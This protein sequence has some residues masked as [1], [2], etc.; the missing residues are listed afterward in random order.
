M[1]FLLLEIV[2]ILT[3]WS[4]INSFQ[5]LTIKCVARDCS[6]TVR[7]NAE[8]EYWMVEVAGKTETDNGCGYFPLTTPPVGLL[9]KN[10]IK[11]CKFHYIFPTNLEL[12]IAANLQ[13]IGGKALTRVCMSRFRQLNLS[14][15]AASRAGHIC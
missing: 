6:I 4:K 5:Y 14:R 1:Q 2:E 7:K 11:F 10:S 8:P 9:I 3:H 15:D 12:A 13:V